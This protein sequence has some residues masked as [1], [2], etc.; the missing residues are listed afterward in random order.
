MRSF[1]LCLSALFLVCSPA[2]ARGDK[3]GWEFIMN[4]E[5]VEVARK[6][7]P[8]SPLFAFRGETELDVPIGKLITVLRDDDIA[9]E[10]VDLMVEH[11]VVRVENID[12]QV[13]YEWYGLPWPISDRDYVMWEISIFDKENLEFTID[14]Y[15]IE[16]AGKP[17]SECCVRAMAY[18]TFWR[19]KKLG[20]HST[21]VE[22]E[23]FTDP[24]GNL[25]AWLINMIQQ[26]WP[27]KTI[28]GL[29]D[30]ARKRDIKPSPRVADW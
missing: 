16:D 7:M 12:K 2:N 11:K 26:D 30:R 20:S 29:R 23:V 4:K 8:D 10:W 25:P 19:L 27:W 1:F 18:K 15:S 17:E 21:K 5:G 3:T 6:V 14:F 28:A 24:K 22:V 13:I 9:E